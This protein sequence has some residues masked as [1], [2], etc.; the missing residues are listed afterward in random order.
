MSAS[1]ITILKTGAIMEEGK[2][3]EA[4]T[5]NLQAYVAGL[6]IEIRWEGINR[7]SWGEGIGHVTWGWEETRLF[8]SHQISITV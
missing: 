4:K 8:P 5:R 1:N 3:G 7:D 6:K 2:Y